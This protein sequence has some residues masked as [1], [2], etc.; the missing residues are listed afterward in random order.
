MIYAAVV[1]ERQA[2]SESPASKESRSGKGFDPTRPQ[3][4]D[5]QKILEP[6]AQDAAAAAFVELLFDLDISEQRQSPGNHK[7]QPDKDCSDPVA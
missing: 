1:G 3:T 5:W 7:D 4:V 2:P 6:V